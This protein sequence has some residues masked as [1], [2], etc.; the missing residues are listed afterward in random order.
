VINHDA[1]V[2][3]KWRR[4]VIIRVVPESTPIPLEKL[5][6]QRFFG[7]GGVLSQ[8]HERYEFRAGQ[9]KMAQAVE[10]TLKQKRHL[11]V[12]AGT[13]TGKTLA[14]LL[15]L[16]RTGQRSIV[17]TGTKNLQEQLYFKDI[18]FLE[19]ALYGTAPGAAPRL[20]VCY[21]KGRN[22]YLCR[23][24]VY[25]LADQ[26]V[27]SGLEEINEFRAIAEWEKSTKT[28]DRAELRTVPENSRLWEKLDAR[29]ERCAGSKCPNF[30]RCFIT[31]MHRRAIESDLI[32]VNHH[33]FFADLAIKQEHS[34]ASILPDAAAVVFDEAHELEDVAGSFFGVS[35]GNLKVEELARD[36]EATIRDKKLVSVRL[37]QTVVTLRER[38]LAFFA[39][40]PEGIGRYAFDKREAFLEE[41]GDLFLDLQSAFDSVFAELHALQGKAEEVFQ[42]LRRTDEM[43]LQLEFL[44]ESQ[45]KNTVFWIERRLGQSVAHAARHHV[46]LQATPIDVSAILRRT[47]FD[48]F[49]AIVLT[50]AT[51]SVG[52]G[53][54]YIRRRLGMENAREL[55]IESHF[56]YAHQA[57][58]YLPPDLPEP[59]DAD[60]LEEASARIRQLLE[61]SRGRAFCLFTSHHQM[62]QVHDKLR[63]ILDYPMLLQGTAPKTALLEEFKATPH[64]VLFATSSFWQGVDVQGEQLSCVIIDRLPFAVPSDPVVAARI[65]AI[66]EDGGNAFMSYQ[67]PSAVITLKQ[68]FGRLIRSLEDRGVVAILDGRITRSRYGGV[69]LNSLPQCARTKDLRVVEKFFGCVSEE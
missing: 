40:L 23:Q 22:N 32:I 11:I 55:I 37:P 25:D 49:D 2:S 16:L 44:L 14:Y 4:T 15:P 62:R 31:E 1:R 56:D 26:P 68:G 51:L 7:T 5:T 36:I 35:V 19:H 20:K 41:H 61:I 58:L 21:M 54:D 60:Y 59:R 43:K 46:F 6:P 12:E 30:E 69:F 66:A 52:G 33:L 24:K 28:G 38:S 10:E 47:L 18:P 67:V 42:L 39:A 63:G 34:E 64:A 65:H 27:L 53:F 29:S 9:L 57:L 17:S 48:N 45:D 50:S 8:T 3:E 13:G